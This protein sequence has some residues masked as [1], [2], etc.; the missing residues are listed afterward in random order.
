MF[1]I[2]TNNEG[3]VIC[4]VPEGR[5]DTLNSDSFNETLKSFFETEKHLVIDFTKCNYL[6]ST[7]IRTLIAAEKKFGAK[8][9][10][11]M[12][13]N[14]QPE[15]FQVLEMAGLHSVFHLFKDTKSAY[16]EFLRLQKNE[17]QSS[18]IE[19]RNNHFQFDQLENK[20][21]SALIWQEQEIVGYNELVVALGI[22]SPAESLVE[23]EENR[24]LFVTIGNC[25]GFIPFDKRILPEFRVLKDPS[26]GG[27][28]LNWALS[29]GQHP[30]FRAKL[31][32]PANIPFS[33]LIDAII[34]FPQQSDNEMPKAILVA[35]FNASAPSISLI[36]F[37]D[38]D[39]PEVQQSPVDG[40][41]S[42]YFRTTENNQQITGARFIL[43][44]LS[45]LQSNESFLNFANRSLTIES[46]E[47][48]ELLDLSAQLSEPTIWLFYANDWCDAATQ[49]IVVETAD[50]F[51]FEP[52]KKYLT[53]RLYDDSARVVVKQLH[54]GYSAQTFQVDSYDRLG[55]KL[56]PTVLKMAN[57]AIIA[58]EADHCQRFS[59]PYIMN[60][61]AMVLGTD[62]FV[63]LALYVIILLVLAVNKP[64]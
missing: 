58:R 14:I 59:L 20:S 6:A 53:R 39:S 32:S 31:V 13:A 28:F 44:H 50:D 1:N 40:Q 52:Y 36:Y 41:L 64:N 16:D 61:S 60:N 49:R 21:Q 51:V 23:E 47:A 43:S 38:K 9:G 45:E 18:V 4:V 63:K 19:I 11:L 55:R 2:S 5:L 46:I 12:L 27:I 10:S 30:K 7:G 42:E 48:I 22:G 56:R 37:I 29:F 3:P 34:K 54:G 33:Q 15:V 57:R 24:G 35:D 17:N 8:G 26:N 25:S 62:S